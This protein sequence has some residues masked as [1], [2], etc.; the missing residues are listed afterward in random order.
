MSWQSSV[1]H[2]ARPARYSVLRRSEPKASS[3]HSHLSIWAARKS[4]RDFRFRVGA[5][6]HDHRRLAE[7]TAA[8]SP[9]APIGAGLNT[10]EV[11]HRLRSPSQR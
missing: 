6:A 8:A 11:A 9:H 4:L 10:F 3:G 5:A 2:A 7:L 1:E